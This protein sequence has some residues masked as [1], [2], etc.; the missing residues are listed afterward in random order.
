LEFSPSPYQF[1]PL[2]FKYAPKHPVLKHP[3]RPW[4]MNLRL[5]YFWHHH[6]EYFRKKHTPQGVFGN[7]FWAL[8]ALRV[9]E[10]HEFKIFKI[11]DIWRSTVKLTLSLNITLWQ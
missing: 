10:D 8:T 6:T 2:R 9:L 7:I 5:A 1:I 11:Y 4:F 3:H